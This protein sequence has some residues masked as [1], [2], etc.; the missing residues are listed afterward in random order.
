MHCGFHE[1]IR[2]P[3]DR[4]SGWTPLLSYQGTHMRAAAWETCCWEPM[5]I[6]EASLRLL[7]THKLSSPGPPKQCHPL[8]QQLP[9]LQP[10][11]ELGGSQ[12]VP[13][14]SAPWHLAART[15]GS[16]VA[17][18]AGRTASWEHFARKQSLLQRVAFGEALPHVPQ[19]SG[20]RECL[21]LASSPWAAPCMGQLCKSS[22][23]HR[24]LSALPGCC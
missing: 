21:T 20:C 5:S 13:P 11:N 14:P 2:S 4:D 16:R 18:W 7:S 23:C 3:P 15:W 19:L 6:K 24:G 1:S 9:Q 22:C 17:S 8:F 12:M 10:G